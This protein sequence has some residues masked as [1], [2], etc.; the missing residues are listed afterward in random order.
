[1]LI[2]WCYGRIRAELEARLEGRIL[3]KPLIPGF[4]PSLIANGI[5]L[6]FQR[7]VSAMI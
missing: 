4:S 2:P 7:L 5:V 1:L 3:P 6:N